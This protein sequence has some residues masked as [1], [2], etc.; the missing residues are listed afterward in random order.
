MKYKV[1]F[2]Q[3]NIYEVYERLYSGPNWVSSYLSQT[4]S[5]DVPIETWSKVFQG[6]LPECEAWIN[7]KE[8]G[9]M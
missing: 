3:D 2:L 8:K 7:L 9:Y 4:I 6:T 5:R 1:Q